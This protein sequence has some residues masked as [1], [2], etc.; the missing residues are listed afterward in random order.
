MDQMVLANIS[1]DIFSIVLSFIP[2]AYLLSNRRY[3][4]KLNQYFLGVSVANIFMIIGDLADWLLKNPSP[5]HET[6][7]LLIFSAIF[8]VASAFVLYF[9]GRY[10]IEYLKITDKIKKCC[11]IAIMFVCSVQ[12]VF[13]I[14]SPFTGYIFF[15]NESGYQR[16]N[17]FWVSQFVP[18]FC[19]LL[20]T[21]LVIVY[22]KKLKLREVV[23][24]LLY[25]FVPLGGGALQMF[26]RGIA[27]VNIGVALALLF[28]LVNIQFERE[29]L[30]KQQEQELVDLHV[31]IM[32]SQIQPHFL[33][34]TLTTIRQLCDINPQLAKDAILDFS[35]FLRGNMDSLQSKDPIPFTQELSHTQHYLRLEQQRFVG[36][37]KI[38]IKTTIVDFKL[39]PLTLQPLVENAVRH[40]IVKK[41]ESGTVIIETQETNNDYIVIVSDDGVGF[42]HKSFTEND[43]SHIGLS[44]VRQRLKASC[45]GQLIINSVIGKGTTATI[46][47]PKKGDICDSY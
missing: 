47:L 35:Y 23:F 19:Y 16:G 7:I 40:G 30:I 18:T 41:E 4:Y 36:R 44:N 29:L 17:L 1:L 12:I 21:I 13:A 38:E 26:M 15:V 25:I 27:V 22:H 45:N 37:L 28:I 10:I 8:Y 5:G 20:F 43:H 2:V 34:N 31:D 33:Y 39:P 3:S 32:L 24:F 42:D 6:T 11:L 46:I 14:I 9:F